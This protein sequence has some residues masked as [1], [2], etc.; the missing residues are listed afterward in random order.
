MRR[1]LPNVSHPHGNPVFRTPNPAMMPGAVPSPI[2]PANDRDAALRMVL[3]RLA[4]LPDA[5]RQAVADAAW[6]AIP[7]TVSEANSAVLTN[8]GAN[9]TLTLNRQ[10]DGYFL[11]ESVVAIVP[12]GATATVIL[13]SLTLPVPAG[14]TSLP[15]L[16]LTLAAGDTRS[17]TLAGAGGLTALILSGRQM[18]T[19]G[20]LAR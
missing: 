5:V 15:K 4:G 8:G 16:A 11:V 2:P 13:G 14:V 19:F 20:V 18:P 1:T 3:D 9:P 12:A 7:L 17:I 10:V 6:A